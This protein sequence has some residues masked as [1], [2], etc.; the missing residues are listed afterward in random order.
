[1]DERAMVK[2]IWRV[3]WN[4]TAPT[5]DYNIGRRWVILRFKEAGFIKSHASEKRFDKAW[6]KVRKKMRKM[7]ERP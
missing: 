3:L 6:E 1:M 2:N 7:G 5:E 4:M